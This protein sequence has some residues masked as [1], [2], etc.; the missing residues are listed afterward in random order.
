MQHKIEAVQANLILMPIFNTPGLA[1]TV[2]G[3][4][5]AWPCCECGFSLTV[6]CS[7]R[8]AVRDLLCRFG[9][10]MRAAAVLNYVVHS[11]CCAGPNVRECA[12]DSGTDVPTPG[13]LTQC[14]TALQCGTGHVVHGR[15]CASVCAVPDRWCRAWVIFC[16]RKNLYRPGSPGDV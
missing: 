10:H 2:T 11:R 16:V 4:T 8:F 7:A 3:I 13:V 5:K 1:R 6:L 12:D 9:R 14:R 15:I